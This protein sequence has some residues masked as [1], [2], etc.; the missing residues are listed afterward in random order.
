M[1]FVLLISSVGGAPRTVQNRPP[2]SPARRTIPAAARQNHAEDL[3]FGQ[4]GDAVDFRPLD[5]AAST[6]DPYPELF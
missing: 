1:S 5:H 6:Q 4:Q 3:I 2:D